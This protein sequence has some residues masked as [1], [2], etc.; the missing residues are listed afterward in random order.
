MSNAF[1]FG[2]KGEIFI[3]GTRQEPFDVLTKG[4]YK[5]VYST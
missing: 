5:A 1:Y 4:S 2:S 3:I